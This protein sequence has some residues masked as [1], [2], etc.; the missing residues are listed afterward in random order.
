MAHAEP[1]ASEAV[2]HKEARAKACTLLT[3]KEVCFYPPLDNYF[4][5]LVEIRCI[6]RVMLNGF[7]S[8]ENPPD[9]LRR[10]RFN[11]LGKLCTSPNPGL[12]LDKTISRG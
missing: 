10:I 4:K 3:L 1:G 2:V 8:A 9:H 5:E 12:C 11:D 6:Q 7:Y